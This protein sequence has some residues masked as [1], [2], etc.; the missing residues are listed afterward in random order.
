M[1]ETEIS[2]LTECGR[3][4]DGA[5]RLRGRQCRLRRL[6]L[7]LTGVGPA[8]LLWWPLLL[9]QPLRLF[10]QDETGA[11]GADAHRD[12]LDPRI[13]TKALVQ[14]AWITNGRP[15]LPGQ[16]RVAIHQPE[17]KR[18]EL[19]E[20][21]LKGAF[22]ALLLLVKIILSK[23]LKAAT[24]VTNIAK[25][26]DLFTDCQRTGGLAHRQRLKKST[27]CPHCSPIDAGDRI[28]QFVVRPECTPE[29]LLN[30]RQRLGNRRFDFEL[31]GQLRP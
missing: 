23:T 15:N 30:L 13:L 5:M 3:A 24:N 31:E 12:N 2:R 9:F 10:I 14:V 25:T 1:R 28:G 6:T 20:Y 16:Y 4:G 26:H 18:T 27:N 11:P 17:L 29:Y 22:K 8:R 21:A 19:R 7:R